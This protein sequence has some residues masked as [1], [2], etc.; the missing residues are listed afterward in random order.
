MAFQRRVGLADD[1]LLDDETW[2][3]LA[4][5]HEIELGDRGDDVKALQYMLSHMYGY[6][7]AVD[8]DFGPATRAA[9]VEFQEAHMTLYR[10]GVVRGDMWAAL[11]YGLDIW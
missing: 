3:K 9:V 4:D 5:R 1:G 8:G 7:L 2:W 10:V 11:I 6:N